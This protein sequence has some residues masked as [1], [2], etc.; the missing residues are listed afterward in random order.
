MLDINRLHK[1]AIEG[2]TEAR[3]GSTTLSCDTCVNQVI[4]NYGKNI[5]IYCKIPFYSS[6]HHIFPMLIDML[7]N[8][9]LY[10]KAS[11]NLKRITTE[12]G[13]PDIQFYIDEKFLMGRHDGILIDFDDY[14]HTT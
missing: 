12:R 8:E 3:Q 7:I 10:V 1:L 2:K 11:S 14:E 6:I 9:G 13:Y 5:T 4:L